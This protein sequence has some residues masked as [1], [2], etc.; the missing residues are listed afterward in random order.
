MINTSASG[1]SNRRMIKRWKKVFVRLIDLAAIN[2][3]VIYFNHNPALKPKY[4]TKSSESLIHALVLPLL[5]SRASTSV[6]TSDA[7]K[8]L[9]GKH[10][11]VSKYPD[12]KKC[13]TVCGY[14]KNKDRK[15]RR[16][17]T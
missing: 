13:C 5:D 4:L 16:K 2:A 10:F 6:E 11:P 1:L 9:Q 14:Q 3:M 17:K 12:A 7:A 8:H 15:R